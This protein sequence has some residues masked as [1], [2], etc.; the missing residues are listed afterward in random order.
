M[1]G[2]VERRWVRRMKEPIEGVEVV[3]DS[4]RDWGVRP[5]ER[6]RS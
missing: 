1:E 6:E 2:V 5:R 3:L 4:R